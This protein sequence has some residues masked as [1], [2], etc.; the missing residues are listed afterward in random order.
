MSGTRWNFVRSAILNLVARQQAYANIGARM[1][2]VGSACSV[3]TVVPLQ[4][5]NL[6]NIDAALVAPTTD[7]QTPLAAAFE[8]VAS[9]FG[10]PNQGQYVVLISDGDETCSGSGEDVVNTASS[11]SRFGIDTFVVAVSAQA[12][13][14]LLDQVAA[15]GRTGTSFFVSNEAELENALDAIY[16]ATNGCF[17]GNGLQEPGEA[18][19]DAGG[20]SDTWSLTPHCDASCSGYAPY[21]GDAQTDSMDGEQC[22]DGLANSDSWSLL[23]HCNAD[24]SSLAPYCGDGMTN[25]GDGEVCDDGPLNRDDWMLD[26]ACLTDCTGLAPYC[27]DAATDTPFEVCDDGVESFLCTD[28]CSA[29]FRLEAGRFH[30]CGIG[31]GSQVRCWGAGNQFSPNGTWPHFG[32]SI[33]PPGRFLKVTTG[34]FHS[35]AIRE[36]LGVFC[37]GQDTVGQLDPVGT[38]TGTGNTC[39]NGPYHLQPCS[40]DADCDPGPMV[41][42]DAHGNSTCGVLLDGSIVCWR[43]GVSV[44]IGTFVRV[45]KGRVASESVVCGIRADGTA[46]CIGVDPN[47]VCAQNVCDIFSSG[48][49]PCISSADCG[50]ASCEPM[51]C[52]DRDGI[53][54]SCTMPADCTSP[55]ACAEAICNG[56][57]RHKGTCVDDLD[58]SNFSFAELRKG[59]LAV[60]DDGTVGATR[61][62]WRIETL[63]DNYIDAAFWGIHG[64]A[65]RADGTVLCFDN[66]VDPVVTDTPAGANHVG[67]S[68]GEE[69]ACAFT[70][71]NTT[72]CWGNATYGQAQPP[73][74]PSFP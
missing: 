33:A 48:V 72:V 32:Q 31:R 73:A 29:H 52:A 9:A 46:E 38:C 54:I 21:C 45:S 59:S 56:G 20:N 58:C 8:G 61:L 5:D 11:L 27:G 63:P 50:G 22:D 12:N 47:G 67:V 51:A 55:S 53:T 49:F 19:D 13:K 44:P 64:C 14:A 30:N 36:D 35:C 26:S 4:E 41:D 37:W 57:F 39:V 15:A 28:Q 65:I 71:D 60:L 43:T 18:C 7:S 69:H 34:E 25:S 2:P 68:V 1:F 6:A 40:T 70:T 66:P 23:P 16:A 62:D 74:S 3:G 17:C 24:C 10:D 42:I